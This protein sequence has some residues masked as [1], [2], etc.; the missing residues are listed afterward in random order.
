MYVQSF[1]QS[2]LNLYAFMPFSL[3]SLLSLLKLPFIQHKPNQCP[4]LFTAEFGD[5]GEGGNWEQTNKVVFVLQIW[6]KKG[7]CYPHAVGC[8][9]SRR[10]S[11]V[12][13]WRWIEQ[14]YCQYSGALDARADN[15][16]HSCVPSPNS[17]I[18]STP[19]YGY[20]HLWLN[21][22]PEKT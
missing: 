9:W 13:N 3:T 14:R 6:A 21:I 1:Y 10:L 5:Q 4:H 12:N 18:P 17:H 22:L 11:A 15:G 19:L 2:K 20:Y 7:S 8:C 16:H